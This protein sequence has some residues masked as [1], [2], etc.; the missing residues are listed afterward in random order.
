MP[1]SSAS[2]KPGKSGNPAGRPQGT[3]PRAR[4][5]KMVDPDM[6][7][8]VKTLVQAAQGGDVAAIKVILDRVVP[9]LKATSD[10]LNLKTTG[11]LLEKGETI[12]SAMLT[13]KA[14]PDQAKAALDALALQARLMDQSDAN[15]RLDEIECLLKIKNA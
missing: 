4:F 9:P 15:K 12:I 2:F 13:G 14:S 5:R 10:S 3:T 1:K 7:A 6:P 8:L 11:T